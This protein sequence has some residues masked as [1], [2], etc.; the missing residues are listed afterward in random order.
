MSTGHQPA[1]LQ[2][3]VLAITLAARFN[4]DARDLHARRREARSAAALGAAR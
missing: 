3:L 4:S 1:T 2:A